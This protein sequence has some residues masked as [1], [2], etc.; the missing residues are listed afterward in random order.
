MDES[1]TDQHDDYYELTDRVLKAAFKVH[2]FCGPGLLESAYQECLAYELT[3]AGFNVESE[4]TMPIIYE[5]QLLNKA[6][7]IDIL[8]NKKLIIEL[9]S[10]EK[11]HKI[12][13]DQVKTYL[14]FSR[15]RVGLLLNFNAEHLRD[16]IQRISNEPLSRG[17]L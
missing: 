2:T 15:L 9:K 10:V 5:G 11:L 4:V 6:Y 17:G 3:Q 13:R 12:H 14:K 1:I 8:V 16:G 7:V